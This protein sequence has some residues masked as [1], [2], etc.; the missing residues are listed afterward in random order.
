[1]NSESAAK[2]HTASV[3]IVHIRVLVYA[4]PAVTNYSLRPIRSLAR[5]IHC[6]AIDSS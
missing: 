2:N 5:S 3:C 1:M 6:W 4:V